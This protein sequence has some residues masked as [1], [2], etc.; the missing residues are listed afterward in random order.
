MNYDRPS[1]QNAEYV[2][3][4]ASIP[5]NKRLFRVTL[6]DMQLA[7]LEVVNGRNVRLYPKLIGPI[8]DGGGSVD[9]RLLS[10]GILRVAGSL[11]PDNV[12]PGGT[13]SQFTDYGW[14]VVAVRP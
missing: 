11:V 7:G 3:S 2:V 14:W 4:G 13:G 12:F 6:K 5:G 9:F 1:M 8:R 10:G